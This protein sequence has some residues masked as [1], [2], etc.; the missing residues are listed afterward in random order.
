MTEGNGTGG[1]GRLD[2]HVHFDQIAELAYFAGLHKA[3]AARPPGALGEGEGSTA[4]RGIHERFGRTFSLKILAVGVLVIGAMA[5]GF[6]R[7]EGAALARLEGKG[8]VQDFV[9]S[10]ANSASPAGG[11]HGE[12]PAALAKE[13]AAPPE[14]IPP[15]GAPGSVGEAS[16]PA[17]FGLRD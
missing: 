3:G 11:A 1:Q 9:P 4:G 13:L 7:G 6:K 5:F 8:S 17:A 15:P 14:V 12:M 2:V 10:P 16:G